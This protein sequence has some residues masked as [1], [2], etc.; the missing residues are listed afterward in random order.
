M[1]RQIGLYSSPTA[2]AGWLVFS[3]PHWTPE[4]GCRCTFACDG[5]EWSV[6]LTMIPAYQQEMVDFFNRLAVDH[7]GWNG[8][9]TW[10]SEDAEVEL[11]V[12][13]DGVL[14]SL[15]VTMRWPPAWEPRRLGSI[16]VDR[17]ELEPFA[18]AL[19]TFAALR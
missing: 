16:Q 13:N 7:G 2:P 14:A 1:A 6:E 8:A 15:D 3:D 19:R 12:E 17:S 5:E 11:S 9:R 10:A 18:T 4:Y